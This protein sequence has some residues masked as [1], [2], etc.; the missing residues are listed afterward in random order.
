V[1]LSA[2]NVGRWGRKGRSS[3]RGLEVILIAKLMYPGST[4][5][6]SDSDTL[7]IKPL[8]KYD[9]QVEDVNCTRFYF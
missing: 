8:Q 1:G 2:R 3:R 9:Y 6:L 4:G 7:M 5:L